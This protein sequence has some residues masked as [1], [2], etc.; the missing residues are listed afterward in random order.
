MANRTQKEA[1]SV[2][3]TNPQYLV[4]KIIR[5]RAYD[6]R[7]WKEECFALTGLFYSHGLGY[8][9]ILWVNFYHS[10][11]GHVV[12]SAHID[13]YSSNL[14]NRDQEI[15]MNFQFSAELV[16][17][18]GMEMRFIG[19]TYGGNLKITP[20]MC[21]LLKMLQIQPDRDIIIEFIKQVG[22]D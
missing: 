21:L 6:T 3:G 5:T 15:N 11:N 18:K 16:V 14:L 19:G 20:F 17:D 1:K 22:F 4:E 8:C 9:T 12:Y 2:R 13:S 10:K 7:Y